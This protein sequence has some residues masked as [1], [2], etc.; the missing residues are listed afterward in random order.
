MC[1]NVETKE[2]AITPILHY[3]DEFAGIRH[4]TIKQYL[5]SF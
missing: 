3:N 5:F 2:N 4:L 1:R